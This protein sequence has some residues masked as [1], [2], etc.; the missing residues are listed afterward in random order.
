MTGL[1]P[2]NKKLFVFLLFNLPF[3]RLESGS[4]F[5]L[6]TSKRSELSKRNAF[7]A[8]AVFQAFES[9]ESELKI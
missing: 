7:S 4:D 8:C 1:S 5:D 3:C 6:E 2:T 9:K